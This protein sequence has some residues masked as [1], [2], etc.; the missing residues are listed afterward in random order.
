VPYLDSREA[1]GERPRKEVAKYSARPTDF[2]AAPAS[3]WLYGWTDAWGANERH[4]FPGLVALVLALVG[5]W[6]T[7]D[8][9]L[10]L[11]GL[12]LVFAVMLALG[13]NAG[14]YR[15]LYD[16]VLPFRGLRVP[17][18]AGILILLGTAVLAG[19][20]LARLLHQVRSQ[21]VASFLAALIIGAAAVEYRASPTLIEV[22]ARISAWYALL[23]RMPDAVVFEWPVTV[24][25]RLDITDDARYMYR[26]TQHWRPLLNGYSGNY[27]GSYLELL[28]EMQAFPYTPALAYLQRRGATVLVVHERPG[29]RP[30]YDEALARLHRDPNI[31]VIAQGHD[32]GSRVTFLRLLPGDRPAAQTPGA[33]SVR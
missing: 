20:G 30:T 27:P 24:A 6:R 4:L 9:R 15:L 2:L 17:A 19:A 10:R 3:N 1:L 28:N 29:S 22:D 26:S 18:R 32:A 33:G 16:W 13:F 31:R 7:A 8:R 11:H 25:W 12:G 14:L 5:V 21:R 23:R